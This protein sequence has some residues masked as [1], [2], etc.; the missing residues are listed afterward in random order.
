MVKKTL[1]G[2]VALVASLTLGASIVN[3]QTQK[4]PPVNKGSMVYHQY[5]MSKTAKLKGAEGS[6]PSDIAGWNYVVSDAFSHKCYTYYAAQPP[7][8]GMTKP[9]A[10]SVKL[11]TNATVSNNVFFTIIFSLKPLE[12]VNQTA[13][14][15]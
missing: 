2:T 5:L 11:A 6:K 8:T 3:A 12:N 10:T 1:F 9:Q 15:G 13:F 14:R 7:L 4:M